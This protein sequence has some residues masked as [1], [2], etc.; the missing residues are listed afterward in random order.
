M[1]QY[2]AHKKKRN[3]DKKIIQHKKAMSRNRPTKQNTQRKHK[4]T[5]L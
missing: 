3:K 5:R 1:T 2:N 4:N